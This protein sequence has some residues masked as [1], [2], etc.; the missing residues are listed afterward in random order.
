VGLNSWKRRMH[1]VDRLDVL[2]RQVGLGQG[3]GIGMVK[4]AGK[5]NKHSSTTVLPCCAC[6]A[7]MCRVDELQNGWFRLSVL[8]TA[9]APDWR[10]TAPRNTAVVLSATK[11][12][13]NGAGDWAAALVGGRGEGVAAVPPPAKKQR[14][15]AAGVAGGERV[16][17]GEGKGGIPCTTGATMAVQSISSAVSA[18]AQEERAAQQAALPAG[19]SIVAAVVEDPR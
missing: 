2:L 7:V 3:F 14:T 8:S 1:V 10:R 19:A 17:G 16:A 5:P 6:C 9:G 12:P 15:G 18:G 4:R 13:Q 11:P